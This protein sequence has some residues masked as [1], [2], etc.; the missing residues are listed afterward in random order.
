[1][2]A[3]RDN[4][5]IGQATFTDFHKVKVV[6]V[7]EDANN[8]SKCYEFHSYGYSFRYMDNFRPVI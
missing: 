6:F 7:G 3:T 8:T 1:M 4:R 5:K 2:R